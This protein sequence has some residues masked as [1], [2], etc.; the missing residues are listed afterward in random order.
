M[1]FSW[2][3]ARFIATQRKAGHG[4]DHDLQRRELGTRWIIRAQHRNS[5]P[6]ISTISF[7]VDLEAG[8]PVQTSQ[9]K[10]ALAWL[11]PNLTVRSGMRRLLSA[12]TARF[13]PIV[14]I[15][16]NIEQIHIWT[17]VYYL[18]MR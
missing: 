2:F 4:H 5:S 11:K 13:T 17:S 1:K 3:I 15:V 16:I 18:I 10:T 12:F 7:W 14:F 9:A 6:G 8:M